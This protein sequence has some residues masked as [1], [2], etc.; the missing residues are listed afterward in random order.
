MEVPYD[1]SLPY[2]GDLSLSVS[3]DLAL[4]SSGQGLVQERIFRVINTS[5]GDYEYHPTYGVGA[6]EYV[7]SDIA[8]NSRFL[9][10]VTDYQ[11]LSDPNVKDVKVSEQVD[12]VSGDVFILVE[13]TDVFSGQPQQFTLPTS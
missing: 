12:P 6:P 11:L 9:A 4:I 7:G 13:Y 2:G 1:L 10:A 3:N 8:E 5:P